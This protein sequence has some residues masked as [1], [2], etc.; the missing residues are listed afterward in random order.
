MAELL[1]PNPP[2]R[3]PQSYTTKPPVSSHPAKT[4]KPIQQSSLKPVAET[5]NKLHVS[6]DDLEAELYESMHHT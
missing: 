5:Y 4:P 2:R 3:T 6:E 1:R